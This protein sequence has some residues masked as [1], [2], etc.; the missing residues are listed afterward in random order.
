VVKAA[1]DRHGAHRDALILI[2]AGVNMAFGFIPKEAFAE[3]KTPGP[4]T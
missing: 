4:N 1:I 3:I 2:L